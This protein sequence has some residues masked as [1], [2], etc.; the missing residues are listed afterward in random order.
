VFELVIDAKASEVNIALL[1]KKK[2]IEFHKEK[3]NNNFTVGDIYLGKVRKVVPSLNA[4]F[5]NVGYEKDAFLHYLDLGP[6]FETLNKF[7][8]AAIHGRMKSPDLG[9]IKQE[10]DIDKGGKITQVLSSSQHV[11]VQIAK[12]P[13]SS[14]GPRLSS[15]I[16]LAGR[17]IVLVPFSN[18]VSISQKVRDAGER[19]RL[20]RL[21]HSIKPKNF[22]VIIRTVAEN[23]K[24]A[25]LDRDMKDLVGKWE[26]CHAALRNANGYKKVLG[27]MNRTSAILRDMLSPDFT[28]V[29]VNSPKLY[30]DLKAYVGDISPGKESIVK[31]YKG[32]HNIMEANGINRQI[33]GA[34]GKHVSMASGAYLIIEHTEAMHVIDVNSGN[35][36]SIGK[37]QELNAIETNMEAAEEIGRQLRLRDMGGIIVVDFIDM[38][39]SSNRKKLFESLKGHLKE[40][41]A[42]HNIIPVSR[43]GV[44]EITRQRVRPE[45]EIKTAEVCPTC[46]GTGEIQPTV[47]V[48]DNIENTLR[49]LIEEAKAKKITL[50]V[51]PLVESYFK[52]GIISRQKKWFLKYK[53][54]VTIHANNSFPLLEY[55]FLNAAGEEIKIK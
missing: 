28:G 34:F 45:T 54:W 50:K 8:K 21:I 23:K 40:D 10:P 46:N 36:K 14:K 44:I 49:Y 26:I 3:A 48:M 4:A 37:T 1:K 42:K 31:L 53:Q 43:F 29:Q 27:E 25:E 7:T 15:E 24:V 55:K 32:R 11:L 51:H 41:R 2:L 9:N 35:R 5:V 13:I 20:K 52:V 17:Y 12:E 33:K 19:E 6:Q 22:G 30:E 47:L 38:G 18:K 39:E 16:T